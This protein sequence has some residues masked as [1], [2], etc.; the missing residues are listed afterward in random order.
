[1]SHSF[2][3]NSITSSSARGH[4]QIHEKLLVRCI[5]LILVGLLISIEANSQ[6]AEFTQGTSGT[7]TMT[8]QVP[9]GTYPGRGLSLPVNLN[10]SSKV[11]RLGYIKRIYYVYGGSNQLAEAIYSEFGTAG[12]TTS[13]DVPVIEWPKQN[14]VYWY[15][16][17]PY[18][19]GTVSPYTFRVSRVFVHM[20]DGSTHELRKADQVYQD[21][22]S[23]DMGGTF[24]AVDGSRMRYDSSNATTGTLYLADGTRYEINSSSVQC[25]DRNGNT[26]SYDRAT[27]QWSDTLGQT[28][29]MPWPANPQPDNPY[30]YALPAVNGATTTYT[31]KFKLLSAALSPGTPALKPVGDFYLPYP[32]QPAGNYDSNN[33]TQATQG[34]SMFVSGLSDPEGENYQTNTRVIGRGQV[35]SNA[36]NPVVLAEVVLPTGLSYKFFYNNYGEL[37]RVTYPS[38]CYQRYQYGQVQGLTP[39][40]IP[41]PQATR[42]M[43]SRWLSANGSGADEVQW[44]Y[45]FGTVTAPGPTGAPDGIKID[46]YF[47]TGGSTQNTFGYDSALIG[48]PYEERVYAPASQGGALIRRTLTSWATSDQTY[49]R[50]PQGTGT[51]TATRNPRPTKTVNLILD[52]GGDALMSATTFQYDTA[53][54]FTVGTDRTQSAEYGFR[55]LNQTTAQTAAIDAIPIDPQALVRTSETSFLTGNLNYRARNILELVSST[56]VKNAAS[57]IVSQS[58]FAYDEAAYPLFPP[59]G[60]VTGWTTPPST[61][62]GNVTTASRWLDYP[63]ATWIST[64]ARYDQC[65]STRYAWDAKG[66]LSQTEYGPAP[67]Y[68]YPALTISAVPDP[69]GIY[70][71]GTSLVSSAVYD[72]KTGL[73]TSSTDANDKTTT[74]EYN[75]P[76]NRIRKV[77][78][79]DGGWTKT[80]YT[81]TF[82][83]TYVQTQTFATDFTYTRDYRRLSVLR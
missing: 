72:L 69:T 41:Y 49:A 70:G 47:Y 67:Q 75:D 6:T 62:R 54:Q 25:I 59:Y 48:M 31:L 61:Y 7:N 22:A 45:G 21:N 56:T 74:F 81:D 19:Y 57:T 27:R 53:Y 35:G 29:G 43:T 2:P 65:G 68:A 37:D 17:K 63:T 8:F 9:L 15:T 13:L 66:N 20:P 78:R 73:V 11:W 33:F 3:G 50:P 76:L 12:W 79:P 5:V 4:H 82:G 36:F 51:Y 26:L 16:G 28:V 30:Y 18:A 14:D 64:H 24:Y 52:T 42:G 71:Q 83:N 77:N 44:L 55:A 39:Q 40:T 10:Y 38:G 80:N 1:M 23:I 58:T 46:T 32:D 60:S 34:A